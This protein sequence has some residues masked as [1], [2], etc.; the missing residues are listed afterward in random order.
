[1]ENIGVQSAD[2]TKLS[3]SRPSSAA[4]SLSGGNTD[5]MSS[6][7][8]QVNY[9]PYLYIHIYPYIKI[10]MVLRYLMNLM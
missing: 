3:L 7:T 6:A 2:T 8:Q 9:I 4:S 10:Q 5:L 1:M